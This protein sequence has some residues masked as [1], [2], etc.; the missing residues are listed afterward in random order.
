MFGLFLLAGGLACRATW[1]L[2]H[3]KWRIKLVRKCLDNLEIEK[4]KKLL[5]KRMLINAEP[6]EIRSKLLLTECCLQEGG[7]VCAYNSLQEADGHYLLPGESAKLKELKALLYFN[8]DNRRDFQVLLE[9]KQHDI[10]NQI[11]SAGKAILKS[12]WQEFQGNLSMAKAELENSMS[13]IQDYRGQILLYNNLARLEG[14]S[15]NFQE[16]LTYLSKAAKLL[17]EKPI[18]LYFSIIYHN[19]SVN[20]AQAGRKAEAIQIMQD[21]YDAIDQ[22]NIQ[23]YLNFSNDY[24]ILA[25]ELNDQDMID[26]AHAHNEKLLSVALTKNQRVTLRVSNLRMIRNDHQPVPDY[27][28]DIKILAQDVKS[29]S[30]AE[31]IS[32]LLEIIHDLQFEIKDSLAG[33]SRTDIGLLDDFYRTIVQRLL[34]FH[35]VIDNELQN[36]PPVLPAVREKWMR[37]RHTLLKL[38]IGLPGGISG[39]NFKRMFDNLEEMARLLRDK[40]YEYGEVEAYMMICDEFVAY[41]QGLNGR[42]HQDFKHRAVNAYQKAEKILLKRL[43]RPEVQSQMIGMAFFSLKFGLD[44]EAVSFWFSNA[45]RRG[46]Q[47]R[48]YAHWLRKQYQEVQTFLADNSR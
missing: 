1:L 32:A 12:Y 11:D 9:D 5:K 35:S 37:H 25:R 43:D 20:L 10:T 42:F 28:E 4:A 18:P 48:H 34:G 47:L 6:F 15:D 13:E 27:L 29:L 39:D 41:G 30:N 17:R 24:L 46:I 38:E 16:Q 44:R 40:S 22:K 33:K 3:E 7:W 45:S 31:Q 8:V 19:F 14:F 2:P 26:K 23:Q 21:Y 36:I